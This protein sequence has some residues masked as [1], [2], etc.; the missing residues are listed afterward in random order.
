MKLASIALLSTLA[1]ISNESHASNN[2]YV[3]SNTEYCQL[4]ASNAT[5]AHLN[6]YSLKLGFTPTTQQC[7]SLV[8][9]TGSIGTH[10]AS[11]G[12]RKLLKQ[13]L[14]GSVLRPSAALSRK[15]ADLP[16]KQQHQVIMKLFG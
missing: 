15:L 3:Y 7:R 8:S 14:K 16:A 6:A 11:L 12:S 10:T 13:A 2:T 4:A 9:N 5:D 1:F